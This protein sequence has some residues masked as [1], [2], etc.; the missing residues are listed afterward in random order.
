[1]LAGLLLWLPVVLP[2]QSNMS[3][4]NPEAEQVIHGN[5]DPAL[6][7]PPVIISH[8][9]S[10]LYGIIN[11][12]AKDTLLKNLERIDSFYNR[13]TGSDTVSSAH[14]IGACRRWIYGRLQDYSTH[15]NNRLLVSYL[16]YDWYK[17]GRE[18]HRNVFAVLPGLDTT[19]KEILYLEGHYDTRCEG[20]CDTACYS[21]GMEDNGSGTVL[22][23]ELARIMSRYAYDRTII[24]AL[25]T[26]E[27]QGLWGAKAFAKYLYNNTINIKACF[28]NDVIGGIICGY[29]SSPPGCPYLNHMDSTHV[30]VFSYSPNNDSSAVSPHKQLA[31]Y[32]KLHQDEKINPLLETPMTINMI[33]TEDRSGRSGDHVPF[34]EKGY[35]AVRFTSQNEHGNGQGIPPDR[36]HTSGD[37][38][39][40]D[41]DIPPD[42][43]IDSF[44]VDMGYLRRNAITNGVNLGY[45]ALSP[46]PPS[47]AFS[48]IPFGVRIQLSGPDSLYQH[49]R[50]GVRSKG[51][52]SLYFDTVYTFNNITELVIDNLVHEKEYYFT[53][54][55]VMNGIESQFP[56]EY[57][58][59]VSGYGDFVA[60]ARG[61]YMH[62]NCPNP[63]NGSTTITID[64]YS[65]EGSLPAMVVLRD[66]AGRVV[67]KIPVRLSPGRNSMEYS[68][69]HGHRGFYTY[70]LE[71]DGRILV[72]RKM[73][74][75]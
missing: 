32:I 8:P 17:C 35:P 46:P 7:T 41:T 55:N 48:A 25:T 75:Q 70:S 73:I 58:L 19:K 39:G 37:I 1:M 11:R 13:N 53:V 2:A 14:G 34:R 57:S 4:S 65:G 38:L 74:L 42:G 6:Y 59:V 47:P 67:G 24:F 64:N 16:D 18:H 72:T 36:Q 40:V 56:D 9:D 12:I 30:R 31:R 69:V 44:Y 52:G 29:T 15:N 61:I 27:D 23:M 54:M 21:P 51:S 26:A 62:Q 60:A 45:L 22:V 10:I 43:I 49:Y 28:N 3:I 71:V 5:Y 20:V 33:I 50:V 66:L 68:N 63:V